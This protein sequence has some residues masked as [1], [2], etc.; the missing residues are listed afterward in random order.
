MLCALNALI[1]IH[2]EGRNIWKKIM[3]RILL[4]NSPD[5]EN[6]ISFTFKYYFLSRRKIKIHNL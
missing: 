4:I 2:F 6:S 3:S 1:L 5:I